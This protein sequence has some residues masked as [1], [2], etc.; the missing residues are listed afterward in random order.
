MYIPIVVKQILKKMKIRTLFTVALLSFS[1][2]TMTAQSETDQIE[3]KKSKSLYFDF[4]P[5][6][7]MFQDLKYSKVQYS[8]LGAGLTIGYRK[9]NDVGL[10]ETALMLSF[11]SQQANTHASGQALA[12]NPT[13]YFKYLKRLNGKLFLGA[14]VDLLNFYFR[15]TAG[16]QNNAANFIN[17]NHLYGSVLYKRP[18]NSKLEIQYAID[19]GLLSFLKE[20]TSFGFSAPQTVLENGGFN[21][22]D[23]QISDPFGYRDF[24]LKTSLNQLNINSSIVMTYKNKL[25]FGYYWQVMQ[26]ANVKSL[27]ITIGTHSLFFK[28]I[29]NKNKK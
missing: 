6:Y 3:T 5:V 28:L 13:V 14:R 9:S 22:Q 17:G 2:F 24:V 15:H 4:G 20:L 16:L 27:P 7:S 23:T 12:A 26:F 19:L 29:L 8:G 18:I 25:S 10:W 1:V 11:S 21:Y